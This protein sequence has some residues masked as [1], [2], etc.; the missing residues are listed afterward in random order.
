MMT[1]GKCTQAL[2]S[3]PCTVAMQHSKTRIEHTDSNRYTL[4]QRED[5]K[6]VAQENRTLS[7]L[8]LIFHIL[9]LGLSLILLNEYSA[10]W[11]AQ[12]CFPQTCTA[13]S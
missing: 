10:I 2:V 9:D 4:P 1:Y 7:A 5:I 11:K 3:T 12:T 8:A 6:M 13:A